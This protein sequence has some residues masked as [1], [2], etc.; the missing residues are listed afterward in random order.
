MRRKT[1]SIRERLVVLVLAIVI[2][3]STIVSFFLF[4]K[5][6]EARQKVEASK[7]AMARALA[8]AVDERL[9]NVQ[10]SMAVLA[11]SR[12][13]R[14]EDLSHF[15]DQALE[16]KKLQ[17]LTVIGLINPQLQP[18]LNT[19]TPYGEALRPAASAPFIKSVFA[20]GYP[21]IT[22]LFKGSLRGTQTFS[23]GVPVSHNGAVVYTLVGGID[24]LDIVKM[25]QQQRLPPGWLAAVV[26]RSGTIV[27]R[28]QDQEL[29]VG[30][31]VRQSLLTRMGQVEEE[32]AEGKSLEDV[33]FLTAFSRAPR[34]G[35][36]VVIGLPYD[37]LTEQLQSS[38][39]WLF[40]GA[41]ALLASGSALA[42]RFGQQLVGSMHSLKEVASQLGRREPVCAPPM[43]FAE[44]DELGLALEQASRDLLAADAVL[45]SNEIQ[46]HQAGS[47]LAGLVDSAMDAIITIDEDQK[48]VLFNRA[49]ER[50]FGQPRNDILD[51]SLLALMPTRFHQDH[52]DMVKRFGMTGITGRRM[53]GQT[54]LFGLRAN[55]EEFPMEASISHLD[56]PEGKLFTVVVRDVTERV[57]AEESLAT[58]SANAS[59]LREAEKRKIARELHDDLAQTMTVL[60]ID[61]I[62]LRDSLPVLTE[63][64]ATKIS[65]M[66]TLLDAGVTATRRIAA[67]LRPLLLDD[68]GLPA[69]LEWLVQGFQE[70]TGVACELD[71]S[72]EI[73]LPEP[74][75]TE[76]F[77]IVQEAL[78]NVSKHA[79][80]THV[81]IKLELVAEILHLRVQD[82]GRGFQVEAESAPQSLGIGGLQE[83][84]ALLKGQMKIVS[85][86]GRGTRLKVE[87]KMKTDQ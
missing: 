32:L 19:V 56:T 74:H 73:D 1:P 29:F 87:I 39:A 14:L 70:R 18:V 24:P 58:L 26:D 83:R 9:A 41:I 50:I 82:N 43:A 53:G 72:G 55:G 4:D 80:A 35:W 12:L 23:V 75:A 30:Q 51:K 15:R 3:L 22:D 16:V 21:V 76:I 77:R 33:Q 38:L 46:L 47:R 81:F 60:K 20:D 67:D 31:K 84:V 66:V 48:I 59:A 54:T 10:D 42:W 52:G 62:S 37:L 13:L 11:T 2:P 44:A 34:S 36:T 6:H 69:A 64:L 40:A 7:I 27:A 5:Y 86:P 28:S 17:Q 57:R 68:L 65:R 45:R 85:A 8:T 49:A 71:M 63:S 25:L 61:L 78:T 79:Q